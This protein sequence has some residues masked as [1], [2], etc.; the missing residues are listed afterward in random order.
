MG[1]LLICAVDPGLVLGGAAIIRLASPQRRELLTTHVLRGGMSNRSV[2]ERLQNTCTDLNQIADCAMRLWRGGEKSEET[3][4]FACED[5]AGVYQG[6]S[7][8]GET[9]ANA[10]PLREVVG[11]VRMIATH[12]GKKF[13]LVSPMFMRRSIGL[14]G[15]AS[16]DRVAKMVRRLLS[17]DLS[18]TQHEV[19]AA[20]VALGA[21]NLHHLQQLE[22]GR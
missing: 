9:N 1:T 8:R 7:R 11:A 4:I 15:N 10:L 13:Y 16:K 21:A 17:L 6:K 19:E 5:Q 3:L 18:V 2:E 14:P 12:L 20:A 22:A